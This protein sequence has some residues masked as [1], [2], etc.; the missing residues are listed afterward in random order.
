M[1]G[2]ANNPMELYGHNE[3]CQLF[4]LCMCKQQHTSTD[5]SAQKKGN[6]TFADM[7]NELGVSKNRVTGLVSV[8]LTTCMCVLW[9]RGQHTQRHKA[10]KKS[11]DR[12]KNASATTIP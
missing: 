4:Y 11:S 12:V 3:V 7:R 8:G 9:E 5:C 6:V 10:M 2:P 1:P